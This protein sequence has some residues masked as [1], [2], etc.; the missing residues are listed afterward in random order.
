MKGVAHTTTGAT[1]EIV[2]RRVISVFGSNPV[3]ERKEKE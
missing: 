1:V 2:G 3:A